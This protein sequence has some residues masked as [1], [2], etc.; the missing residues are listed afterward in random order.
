MAALALLPDAA[1][2]LDED[3][4]VLCANDRAESMFGYVDDDVVGWPMQL[5]L[6]GVP[7]LR[8]LLTDEDEGVR[9]PKLE[10]RR[11]SGVPFPVEAGV[12]RVDGENG[13]RVV[14]TLRELARDALAGEAQRYFDVAFDDAP[15]GMALFNSDG[16]YVRVNVALCRILD[17]SQEE[18]LGRRDQELTHPADRQADV[19]AAWDI[20]HGRRNTHQ[21]EKR[22][23]RPDGSVVWT[24]ANL[25]FLRDETGRPLSWVGQF[26]DITAR[27]HAEEALRRERDLSAAILTSMHDGF[28]FTRDGEILNVNESLCRLTGFAREQ[29]V[30]ARVPFPFWPEEDHEA[31]M[32]RRE[33]LLAQGGGEIEATLVRRDGTRFDASLTIA[34]AAG[35]DGAAVGFVHAIRDISERKRHEQ[36]L[37]RQA[38]QD[39]LTGLL[40]RSAFR[41]RLAEEA[42]RAD[43]D[44]LPLSLALLDLDHFKRINDAHGHPAGDRALIE[45]ADRLRAVSRPQDHLARVGGEEFAWLVP[46]G[47]G[48]DAMGA[49]ERA[50]AAIAGT[51]LDGLGTLTVSVGVCERPAGGDI[52][53]LYRLA[54]T[55][56]YQAKADGRD[57]CR[58]A[59]AGS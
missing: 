18:L 7:S 53:E 57:R 3:G 20:L 6:P 14:C 34:R 43:R 32:A 23:V 59:V 12:R 45:V 21:C 22:F 1:L 16:E 56:L 38:T 47:T 49:A 35:P 19:D 41:R 8:A 26:Q 52:D 27:R 31:L 46:A 30:G 48:A 40:N 13:V 10:G 11:A 4:T 2:V 55:A 24:L 54:D 29:L 36:A 42:A 58:L 51:Q 37:E 44:G 39:G 15:I 28:A 25:T 33:R 17:R 9:R 50:R 5:L